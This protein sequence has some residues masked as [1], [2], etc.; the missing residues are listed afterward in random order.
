M[1]MIIKDLY[2]RVLLG[3]FQI[4][5]GSVFLKIY[6]DRDKNNIWGNIYRYSEEIV[7]RKQTGLIYLIL[8]CLSIVGGLIVLLFGLRKGIGYY[9]N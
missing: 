8:G 4:A 6:L 1:I 2:L 7:K 9:P 3:I 5:V